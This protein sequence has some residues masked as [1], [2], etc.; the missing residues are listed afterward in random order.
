MEVF[1][2]ISIKENR[3]VNFE[4]FQDLLKEMFYVK[5]TEQFI[6]L[7]QREIKM[8]EESNL[9]WSMEKKAETLKLIDD[10]QEGVRDKS[11]DAFYL[12][13]AHEYLQTNNQEYF[14]QRLKSIRIPFTTKIDKDE[15]IEKFSYAKP[16]N[17]KWQISVEKDQYGSLPVNFANY[18]NS[19]QTEDYDQ[20]IERY[21]QKIDMREK[22]SLWNAKVSSYKVV[23]KIR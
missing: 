9:R 5:E 10:L 20:M 23:E 2:K 19:T 8:L 4:V 6:L 3:S 7:K 17:K 12:Y 1:R 18:K 14:T 13:K 15:K 21:F 22:Q 16:E 11:K